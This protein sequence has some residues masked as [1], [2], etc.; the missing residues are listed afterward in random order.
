VQHL[1][2][3]PEQH[4]AWLQHESDGHIV[5]HRHAIEVIGRLCQFCRQV[6]FRSLAA[7]CMKERT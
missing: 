4:L 1:E 6:S 7:R 5:A 2:I 3:V